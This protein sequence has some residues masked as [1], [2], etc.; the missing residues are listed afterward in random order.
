MPTGIE[1]H[2]P[3]HI[4]LNNQRNTMKIKL[5]SIINTFQRAKKELKEKEL[6]KTY[7]TAQYFRV[8]SGY[9]PCLLSDALGQ[10]R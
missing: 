3:H 10:Q 7:A 6:D 2:I 4:L 5:T 8:K 9:T 1:Q